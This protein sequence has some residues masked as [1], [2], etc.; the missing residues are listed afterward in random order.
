VQF[1]A[2][3]NGV[4]VNSEKQTFKIEL[5]SKDL[6]TPF[7]MAF[8]PDGRI[9]ITERPGRIRIYD[10]GQLSEPVKNTPK[11]RVQQDGGYLDISVHPDFA[12]N[13]W[14]YLSFSEV[15]PGW[16]PPALGSGPKPDPNAPPVRLGQGPAIPANTVV[17]RGKIKNNEWVEQ[18]VIFRSPEALYSTRGEHYGSRFAWDKQHHLFFTLGERGNMVNA[19]TLTDKNSLGKIHRINDDGSVPKDNPFVNTPGS[20]PTVWSY[21]HRNPEGLAFN[22]VDGKLWESE[23]GPVGGDEINIIEP[24]KNYGWGVISMGLQPGITE[25]S[26]PGMEQPVVYYTPSAAPAQIAFYS[27]NKYPRWKNSLFVGFLVGQQLRRLEISG[28]KVTHQEVVFQQ[29]GRV[30]DVLQGPDGYLY[31]LL[32]EPTGVNGIPLSADTPGRL[33]RLLPA[34]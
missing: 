19:Q 13:G 24:G 26:H 33:V 32:Q 16:M 12:K 34:S 27:G 9:L 21:G 30:R 10:K 23:H 2:D 4:V 31:L 3:P 18:Q 11:A 6:V 29:F 25:Q 15:Q 22:P 17:V 14:V 7:G 5:L 1:V 8:L 20:D 28:D